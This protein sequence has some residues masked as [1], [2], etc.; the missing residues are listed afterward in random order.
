M[1][2]AKSFFQGYTDSM[3]LYREC[4]APNLMDTLCPIE[5]T[6]M[7]CDLMQHTLNKQELAIMLSACVNL[8]QLQERVGEGKPCTSHTFLTEE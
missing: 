2:G 8:E 6:V 7:I 5:K 4:F 1:R 3:F